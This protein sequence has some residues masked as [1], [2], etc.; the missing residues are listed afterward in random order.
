MSDLP[1]DG[2]EV[3]TYADIQIEVDK[4]FAGDWEKFLKAVANPA[5]ILHFI[6]TE[7]F[8][9]DKSKFEAW[10]VE[11]KLPGD[12]VPRFY[13]TLTAEGELAGKKA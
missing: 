11:K 4:E 6:L 3:A 5:E 8:E 1:T 12:W 7:E 2:P 10:A 13:S 9:L